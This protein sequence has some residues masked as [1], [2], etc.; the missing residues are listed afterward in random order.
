MHSVVAGT[1][2]EYISDLVTP[3]SELGGCVHLRKLRSAARGLY[4]IPGTHYLWCEV[5]HLQ[6]WNPLE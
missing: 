4:D 5:F 1:T 3:G 6:R 2:P